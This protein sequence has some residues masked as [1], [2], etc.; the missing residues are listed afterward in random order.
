MVEFA[1]QIS[2]TLVAEGIETSVELASV[3]STTGS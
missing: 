1:R 2:A 3:T